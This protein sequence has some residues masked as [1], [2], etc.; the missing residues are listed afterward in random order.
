MCN[1][2]PQRQFL[3]YLS[4]VTEFQSYPSTFSWAQTPE[5]EDKPVSIAVDTKNEDVYV[6]TE[7]GHVYLEFETIWAH[8]GVPDPVSR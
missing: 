3:V 2:A 8:G 1:G 6:V 5:E 4:G 7:A